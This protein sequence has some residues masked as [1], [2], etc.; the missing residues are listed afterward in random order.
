MVKLLFPFHYNLENG[1]IL[2]PYNNEYV[3]V[4]KEEVKKLIDVIGDAFR[5]NEIV[6]SSHFCKIMVVS[7]ESLAHQPKE[8]EQLK[9][10]I[11]SYFERTANGETNRGYSTDYGWGENV[12]EWTPGRLADYFPAIETPVNDLTALESA[13]FRWLEENDILGDP[14]DAEVRICI[15]SMY[16]EDKEIYE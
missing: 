13:F 7:K 11:T 1:L 16:W 10:V 4:I 6:C 2:E 8:S 12:R 15:V 14:A 5:V 9:P 3:A